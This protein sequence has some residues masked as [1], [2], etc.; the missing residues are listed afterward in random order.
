MGTLRLV[1]ALCVVLAHVESIGFQFGVGGGTA[2]QCF[3]ILSGFFM[4]LILNEKYTTSK[5]NGLFFSN[6]FL[7]LFSMYWFFLAINLVLSGMNWR[8][9]H[10]GTLARINEVLPELSFLDRG[11]LFFSNVFILGHDWLDFFQ[12]GSH[13]FVLPADLHSFNPFVATL[14]LI[15]QSWTLGVEL[16][17]YL[18]APFLLRK[19]PAVLLT[20]ALLSSLLRAVAVHYGYGGGYWF[21]G[22][23]PFELGM[24]LWG[25]LS[26]KA[27]ARWFQNRHFR[28]LPLMA[29]LPIAVVLGSPLFSH[30]EERFFSIDHMILYIVISLGLPALFTWTMRNRWDRAIGE[31]SYPVYLCHEMF[32]APFGR[33]AYLTA[34]PRLLALTVILASCGLSALV[35]RFI[36]VPI[37]RFREAR[38]RRFK[39]RTVRSFKNDASAE[40]A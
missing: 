9:H 37:N 33:S 5:Q 10:A 24:F 38:V 12:L 11:S 22:F 28:L 8:V 15:P 34:H 31:L 13:G 20:L 6:R 3:Y 29:L 30:G 1:L 21:N 4:A 23:F 19:R 2:V 36:D 14:F 17:F 16:T 32:I 27:Y 7:R 40:T 25:A 35:V 26:Y 39:S 18:M